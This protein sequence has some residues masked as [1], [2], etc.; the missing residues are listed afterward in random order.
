L[1]LHDTLLGLIIVYTAFNLPFNIWLLQG[2]FAEIPQEL[3]DAA[4]IDGCSYWQLFQKIMLPLIAPGL[5]ASAIFCLLL[6]WNEFAFALTLTYT[7]KSQT[8]PIAI[9]GMTNDRGTLFGSMGAVG[10]VATLPVLAFAIYV[11][12]YLVQGLTA[13]AI[14]G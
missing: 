3:E 9:A 14:K 13:G 11:Q 7:I 4:L 12:K 8:L 6:S 10:T 5:V 2:F 1:S